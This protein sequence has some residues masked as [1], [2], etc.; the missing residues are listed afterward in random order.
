M[1][2]ALVFLLSALIIAPCLCFADKGQIP[3]AVNDLTGEG[4]EA[5]EARIIS[6]RF[7]S[8]LINAQIFRVMERGE[9]E[10]ILKE[11]GFQQSGMCNDKS[12]MVEMGQILG[13][14]QI[15]AGT[16]GKIG[17]MYTLSTRM[18]DVATG[19]VRFS[20]TLD[21]KCAI[22]DVLTKSVPSIAQQI[23]EKTKAAMQAPAAA[24]PAQA[25][26]APA[27]APQPQQAAQ[28]PE[29]KKSLF[30][31]WYFWVPAAVVVCGGAAAAYVVFERKNSEVPE[32]QTGGVMVQW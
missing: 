3:I 9:M 26:P 31:Q 11:Q 20:V 5:S 30:T 23:V 10:T 18:I 6:D 27:A 12:C 4:V 1:K 24:Q 16:I 14:K 28:K 29:K 22:S 17:G 13:V 7:R 15:F 21:C 2:R 19:E 25:A 8:E 32:Q